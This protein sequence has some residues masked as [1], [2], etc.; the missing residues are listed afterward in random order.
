M[1]TSVKLV[2]VGVGAL[3]A[4]I[5]AAR[6]MAKKADGKAAAVSSE[7]VKATTT[8]VKGV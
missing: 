4:G 6:I 3:V 1:K 2:V 5:F 8:P 7:A